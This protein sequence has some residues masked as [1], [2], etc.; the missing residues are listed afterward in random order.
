MQT[1]VSLQ[2]VVKTYVMGENEVHALRGISFEISDDRCVGG[3][4][5]FVDYDAGE[6]G[7]VR[8]EGDAGVCGHGGAAGGLPGT[9]QHRRPDQRRKEQQEQQGFP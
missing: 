8:R 6:G 2:N 3:I 4:E 7:G 1:V 9:D 5:G